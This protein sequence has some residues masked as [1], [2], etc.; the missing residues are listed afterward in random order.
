[1]TGMLDWKWI[2]IGVVVMIVLNLVAG[3]ILGLVLAPQLEGVTSPEE[4]Q[5]TGGQVALATV[6]NFLAFAIGG[7]IVGLKSAGRTILEP[8]ISAAIAVV[9]ALLISGNF[10]IVNIMVGGIV[11]FLAGVLGGWLGEKRQGTV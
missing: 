2:G 8:G 9:I 6:L 7:F 5:L 1:M 3:L 4:V 10:S 11:P